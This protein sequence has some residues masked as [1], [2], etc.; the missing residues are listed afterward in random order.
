MEYLIYTDGGSR[1]NPGHSGAG[2]Y[3]ISSTGNIIAKISKYLGI[4]TNN[5]AEYK[6]LYLTLLKAIELNI[7]T[8]PIQ[9]YMDS[10]LVIEQINGRWKVKHK[11]LIPLYNDIKELLPLFTNIKFNHILINLNKEAD[12]L[13]NEAMDNYLG[14]LP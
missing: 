12:I 4:Q 10:K 5:Y 13:A 6:S 8:F 7:N 2:G 3:I 1:G 9:V 14:S 11:N